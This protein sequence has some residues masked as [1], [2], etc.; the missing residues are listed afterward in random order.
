MP[1]HVCK[2]VY[3][4]LVPAGGGAAAADKMAMTALQRCIAP[5]LLA[6]RQELVNMK[7]A[8]HGEHSPEAKRAAEADLIVSC[9]GEEKFLVAVMESLCVN[10]PPELKD[11]GFTVV[12]YAASASFTQQPLDVS[13]SFKSMKA[14]VKSLFKVDGDKRMEAWDSGV[15]GVE[16]HLDGIEDLVPGR[17]RHAPACR[18]HQEPAAGQRGTEQRAL[19]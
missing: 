18:Q 5:A 1:P 10:P 17:H 19:R 8:M 7:V 9:D 16:G 15:E 13:S 6:Q 3:L 11:K 14:L 4:F 12:K 2:D